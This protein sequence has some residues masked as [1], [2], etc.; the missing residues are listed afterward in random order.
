VEVLYEAAYVADAALEVERI[1]RD[2]IQLIGF[3]QCRSKQWVEPEGVEE[4]LDSQFV[5][6]Y[7]EVRQFLQDSFKIK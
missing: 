7:F 5:A 3:F 6:V 4:A 1:R 2:G